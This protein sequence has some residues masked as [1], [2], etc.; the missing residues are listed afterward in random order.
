[1]EA[2]VRERPGEGSAHSKLGMVYA[3]LGR[4]DDAVRE[5][6]LGMGLYNYD[7][8]LVSDREWELT[9]SYIQLGEYETALDH[10]EH[11]LSIP[12]AIS[13]KYLEVMPM[14]DPLRDHPRFKKI[15]SRNDK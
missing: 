11:L 7:S 8:I 9:K 5:G 15:I 13:V 3:V 10:I 4:R 2:E 1:M 12:S 6:K 14:V